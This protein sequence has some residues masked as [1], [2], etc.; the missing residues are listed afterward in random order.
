MTY[1]STQ[2]IKNLEELTE[3]RILEE[4]EGLIKQIQNNF[5][6]VL[7]H[8][9][10]QFDK[11]TIESDFNKKELLRMPVFELRRTGKGVSARPYPYTTDQ[12][13]LEIVATSTN[14]GPAHR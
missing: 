12:A 10:H 13:T 7:S 9:I 5:D 11:L 14:P 1:L 2:N 6:S 3:K 8:T 4:E